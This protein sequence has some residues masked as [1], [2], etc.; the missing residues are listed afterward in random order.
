MGGS[1]DHKDHHQATSTIRIDWKI[2]Y[3][4]RIGFLPL[5][6]LAQVINFDII[7]CVSLWKESFLIHHAVLSDR[8]IFFIIR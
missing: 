7:L 1:I 2:I 5:A 3:Y 4:A 6:F 8:K